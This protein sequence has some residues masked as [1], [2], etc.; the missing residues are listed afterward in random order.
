MGKVLKRI[1][2]AIGIGILVIVVLLFAMCSV[3]LMRNKTYWEYNESDMPIEQKYNALGEYETENIE[4]S[5]GG[6]CDKIEVWYPKELKESGGTYPLVIMANGTGVKASQ[7]SEVFTHLAS[8]GFIVVGNEDENS[9]TGES[10]AESLDF[11]LKK[12]EE[13]GNLF[14][15]KIDTQNIGIAGHS[16]GGVGAMN[17]VTKKIN[18]EKYKAMWT[19]SATSR[20]HAKGLGEGWSV[21]PEKIKIPCFMVA[22]TKTTDAGNMEKYTDTLSDG[23]IQGIC[24]LWWLSECYNAATGEKIIARLTDK[25]HGDMLRC[26]DGYMTAWFCYHLKGDEGAKAAFYGESAEILSNNNWQDVNKNI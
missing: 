13:Q 1:F 15:G 6:V 26:A 24:P 12:S 23:E 10:S 19:A 4:Y 5:V 20:Y 16:Q 17:A 18:G 9:R 8:W 2:I 7:Y 21:N 22:G 11:M 25:D 14:C 3:I